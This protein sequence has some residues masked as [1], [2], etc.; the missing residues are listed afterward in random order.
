MTSKGGNGSVYDDDSEC[1]THSNSRYMSRHYAG[2]TTTNSL[3]CNFLLSTLSFQKL[4]FSKLHSQHVQPISMRNIVSVWYNSIGVHIS[5]IVL[6]TCYTLNTG[7]ERK[8]MTRGL[9]TQM[10][11]CSEN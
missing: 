8:T 6:L 9:V 4:V 2:T 10:R 1:L 11:I 3:M 5:M 7:L